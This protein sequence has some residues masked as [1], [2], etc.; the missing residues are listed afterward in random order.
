M[1]VFVET[2]ITP[3]CP[4]RVW[5]GMSRVVEVREEHLHLVLKYGGT[6]LHFR[7]VKYGRQPGEWVA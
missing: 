3:R 4:H 6:E 5:D 2:N 1:T 7:E